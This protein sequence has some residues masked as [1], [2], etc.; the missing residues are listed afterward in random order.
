[1]LIL[2]EVFFMPDKDLSP[3]TPQ[4]KFVGACTRSQTLKVQQYWQYKMW[5]QVPV[6]RG[7]QF[8]SLEKLKKLKELKER[9]NNDND[10]PNTTKKSNTK[11][12]FPKGIFQNCT[13]S[14]CGTPFGVVT[15]SHG[16]DACI[17]VST[18]KKVYKSTKSSD[19]SLHERYDNILN[20]LK[21]LG[22]TSKEIG[23]MLLSTE[24]KKAMDIVIDRVK[25][26]EVNTC[27]LKRDMACLSAILFIAEPSR[28]PPSRG[29]S[30]PGQ[31]SYFNAINN[32]LKEVNEGKLDIYNKDQRDG[33]LPWMRP[34]GSKCLLLSN[35]LSSSPPNSSTPKKRRTHPLVS[36]TP[37]QPFGPNS[38]R[39]QVRSFRSV[40]SVRSSETH[41]DY[42]PVF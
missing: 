6:F 13:N 38:A 27:Q 7:E 24:P 26:K 28:V 35:F 40:G 32:Y 21:A 10:T 39:R 15:L 3:T 25:D 17:K 11:I 33:C 37:D 20:S 34:R 30:V 14:E 4:F 16:N 1:M 23:S 5:C 36:Q 22:V 8:K 2:N 18:R 9:E 29:N 31:T 42:Q 41:I 12:P 19:T